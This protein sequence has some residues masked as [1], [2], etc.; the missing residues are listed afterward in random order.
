MEKI[1]EK[2]IQ[3]T[4]LHWL[5][6]QRDCFSFTVNTGGVYDPTLNRFRPR[7]FGVIRGTPDILCCYKPYQGHG[8]MVG[9]EVKIA[10]GRQSEHQKIFETQIK[11]AGGFYFIV[12]SIADV[13]QALA[14]VRES[15]LNGKPKPQ[16]SN[17][18]Q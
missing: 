10:K 2:Q 8:V 9:L 12:R 7:S 5:E 13:Q 6:F 16:I 17:S 11:A 14:H 15:I 18:G 3:N 4:I 1:T